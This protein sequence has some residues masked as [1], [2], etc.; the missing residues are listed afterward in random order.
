MVVSQFMSK[1]PD[2]V[3]P[4]TPVTE[5]KEL[6]TKKNIGKLPVLDKS[7][8][9]VGIVTKKDLVN[10]APS[11]AT[12]LD[13]YEISYLLSKLRV[14]KIMSKNVITVQSDE[15]VEEAARVM[16][17]NGIGCLPVM[18]DD[19]LIG[20]ITE[21][22]LFHAF[23]DMFAARQKGV[24]VTFMLEEKPGMLARITQAI[25]ADNG[26]IISLVTGAADDSGKR[27]CACKVEGA[28]IPQM[29]AI[30]TQAGAVIEDVR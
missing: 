17:D 19:I 30:L 20:I 10:A 27:R 15:V 25:S 3:H 7:N 22:D 5:A 14:E 26:N 8:R 24:R 21:S 13:M 1:N 11:S 12:T 2:V 28:T 9:L 4:D 23:V 18:K 6:M 29:T 16:A